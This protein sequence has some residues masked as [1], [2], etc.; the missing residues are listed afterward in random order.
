MVLVCAFLFGAPI[1]MLGIGAFRNAE[2]GQPAQWSFEALSTAYADG[3]TYTTLSNSI[4]LATAAT[5][6]STV[7]AVVLAFLVTRTNTPLRRLVTPAM[8]L[9]VALPPLYYALGWGMLGNP[10]I[11]WI[12]TT[13][14]SWTGT[15]GVLFSTYSWSGLILVCV[16]KGVAINYL[17]LLGPFSAMDRTLEEA[18]Q[19]AGANRL[20]TVLRIDLPVLAPAITGVAILSFVVGL[21]YFDVPLLLGTPAGLEVFST[22]IYG[23]ITNQTPADYGAA[24][25]LAL[26][27]V[28]IV[29]VLVLLQWKLL[30]NRRFTTVTGKSYRTDRWDIGRAKWLGAAFIFV[31]ISLAII[32]PLAQLV[33]GSLQPF[34]GGTGDLSLTNYRWLL[35]NP[36]SVRALRQTLMIALGAGLA[37]MIVALLVGYALTHSKSPL[38][39]L[40]DLLTWLPW[41]VPG[42]IL[43]LGILWMYVSTPGLRQLYGTVWIVMLG[44]ITAAVPIATRSVQPALA[45]ISSELEEASRVAGAS[46]LR[47]FLGIVVPLISRSFLAGW[48]VMAILVSGNLAIPILLSTQENITVPI[49]VLQLHTQGETSRAAALFVAL[50]AILL[51]GFIAVQIVKF[52]VALVLRRRVRVPPATVVADPLGIT[53][54]DASD[55]GSDRGSDSTTSR[56]AG[57]SDLESSVAP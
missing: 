41:A 19:M 40:L 38:R 20:R 10:R 3:S 15:D 56:R 11:G 12:N 13:W 16:L 39:R 4:I 57:A 50:L 26:L 35:E 37:A 51:L 52:G 1:L 14:Q 5:A 36:D 33:V 32:A 23:L 6:G 45:Q 34:F 24:S 17:L 27:L 18:S 25:A 8:V 53:S 22:Q 44:L 9:L 2:P 28:V 47:M 31:Y 30:G 21:E 43:S 49:L 42:V 48:F 54:S 29:V 46:P 55:G 7:I